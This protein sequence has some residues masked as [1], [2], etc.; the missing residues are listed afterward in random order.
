MKPLTGGTESKE[1]AAAEIRLPETSETAEIIIIDEPIPVLPALPSI[2]EL[3]A[4][5]AAEQTVDETALTELAK[6]RAEAVRTFLATEAGIDESRLQI[7]A[8]L[9]GPEP[10]TQEAKVFL[11]IY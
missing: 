10:A 7:A 2:T 9:S 4:K 8:E 11:G 1:A 3:E 5:L 6:E